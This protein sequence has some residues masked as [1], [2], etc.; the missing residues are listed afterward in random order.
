MQTA[1]SEAMRSTPLGREAERILRGCVHCGFC[2]ATCPTY[3]LTGDEL[4]GPRGR[5]YLIK[6]LL[7]G[8]GGE[9]LTRHHL[10]RCLGCR[11][12]ETTCPS[13][14]RYGRLLHLGQELLGRRLERGAGER[15]RRFAL[16]TLVPHRRAFGA[17]LRL[18]QALRPLLPQPLARRVPPRAVSGPWPVARHARRMLLLESCAQGGA[19]PDTNAAAARVLDR[20]GFTLLR[21]PQAGCCGA[22]DDHLGAAAAAKARACRNIDAWWPHIEQGAEAVLVTASGCG[23]AVKEYGELLADDP[24]YAARAA[25]VAGLARDVSEVVGAHAQRLAPLTDRTI[26]FHA[27]CS[28]QHGQGISGLAESLLQRVGYR[29]APV[30]E[31]HLCCG[32]AG[33]YSLLQPVLAT[34]LRE[35]KLDALQAGGPEAIAT[36]NIGCQLHLQGGTDLPVRHWIE[37]LDAAM[38]QPRVER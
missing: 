18:G 38:A 10:D 8:D 29:L 14:V 31:A 6:S 15:L 36:A 11:A 12:C 34:A 22:L 23:T 28:L 2:T 3:Q 27:P 19:S 21:V 4:D 33:P 20:L 26:A 25:R 9:A 17:L 13:G 32:S 7:E 16:R 37:L 24:H 35:R 30:T 5:I 1:I